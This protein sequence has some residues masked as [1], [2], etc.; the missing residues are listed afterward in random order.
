MVKYIERL[1]LNYKIYKFKKDCEIR[2]RNIQ[3]LEEEILR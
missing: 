2:V 3:E 1:K